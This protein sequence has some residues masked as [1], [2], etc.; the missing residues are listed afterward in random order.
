[1]MRRSLFIRD[2]IHPPA[3][4]SLGFAV[5]FAVI[6]LTGFLWQDTQ[7]QTP[8]QAT[9]PSV[10]IYMPVINNPGSS[11]AAQKAPV[12]YL[13]IFTRANGGSPARQVAVSALPPV[14]PGRP[15][16]VYVPAL[17]SQEA[18]GTAS[19][20]PVTSQAVYHTIPIEGSPVDRPAPVNP[21]LNL[22]IRGYRTA[23]AALGLV[24]INGP[25][26]DDAPQLAGITSGKIP[27]FSAGYQVFDWDWACVSGPHGCR[28]APISDVPVTLLALSSR[29][30]DPIRAPARHAEI[31]GG[32]YVTMVLYA[33]EQRITLTYTR[34]DTPAV[35]YVVHIEDVCVD[36]NLLALYRQSDT[37]GRRQLPALHH[38]EALGVAVGDQFKV[39][40]RDSGQFMDPRSRKDWWQGD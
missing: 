15:S 35:G 34:R 4:R 18:E 22:S 39:A 2:K 10:K 5:L 21:D 3:L 37:S 31:Y 12:I 29:A 33:E 16:R 17:T 9:I 27:T 8:I 26:D 20:C 38:A 25:T 28:S 7:A 6:A 30:G 23:S 40:V 32:G 36:P 14:S 11:H 1:M 24:E 19:V 13:P